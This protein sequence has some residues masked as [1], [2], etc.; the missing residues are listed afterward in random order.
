MHDLSRKSVWAVLVR[1]FCIQRHT[2][3]AHAAMRTCKYPGVCYDF[4][5]SACFTGARLASPV[6]RCGLVVTYKCITMPH[7]LVGTCRHL[8]V[9]HNNHLCRFG[10]TDICWDGNHCESDGSRLLPATVLPYA[11][12]AG[13]LLL[14]VLYGCVCWLSRSP[15][16]VRS[17]ET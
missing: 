15:D 6:H 1:L 5:P 17:F 3:L 14:L 2:A 13:D 7:P 8:K 16:V 12:D 10:L 4:Y 11:G 9:D